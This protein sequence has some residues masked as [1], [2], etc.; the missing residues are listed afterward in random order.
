MLRALLLAALL[1][2]GLSLACGPKSRITCQRIANLVSDRLDAISVSFGDLAPIMPQSLDVRL[3][4]RGGT[5]YRRYQGR[6]AYDSAQKILFLPHLMTAAPLPELRSQ[7]R[8][9]WPFYSDP[10][11]QARFP[12]VNEIDAVLWNAYLQEAARLG[13]LSWPH[14]DCDSVDSARRLTCEMVA[15]GALEYV[16]RAQ[17]RIFNANR[18]EQIWPEK[19]AQLAARQ[20]QPDDSKIMA[21]KRYGGV[22][23]LQPLV[24]KFGVPRVLAYIAQTPF[25]VEEDNMRLSALRFQER[26]MRSAM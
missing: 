8:E 20:W 16:N 6:P 3:M 5:D 2:P 24:Q 17:P 19:Y 21:V 14:P 23:L 11:L 26:A 22:L 4:K 12:L 18:I 10:D 1:L 7:T 13:G 25:H 9:Y 15:T